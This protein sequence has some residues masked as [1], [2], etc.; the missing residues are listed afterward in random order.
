MSIS[1]KSTKSSIMLLLLLRLDLELLKLLNALLAI[2]VW[3]IAFLLHDLN[4]GALVEGIVAGE[5]TVG[6]AVD[7]AMEAA[8][9]GCF[10]VTHCD[11]VHKFPSA[12][13][14]FGSVARQGP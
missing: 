2:L 14:S 4:A 12:S 3:D 9:D 7:V 5:V 11:E 6:A 8:K 13:V 10:K 1:T